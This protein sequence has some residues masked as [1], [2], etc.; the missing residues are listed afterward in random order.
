MENEV[1][2]G[3]P[4]SKASK[5][6]VDIDVSFKRIMENLNELIGLV[7]KKNAVLND[8]LNAS[9]KM[10]KSFADLVNEFANRPKTE[11]IKDQTVIEELKE[12]SEKFEKV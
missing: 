12:L 5:A 2:V 1:F 6:L 9:L 4:K 3:I 8:A 11:D 10:N 7:Q